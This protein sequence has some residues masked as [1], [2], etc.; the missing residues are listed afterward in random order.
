MLEKLR[1]AWFSFFCWLATFPLRGYAAKGWTVPNNDEL[2][3]VSHMFNFI[4]NQHFTKDQDEG[5]DYRREYMALLRS[6][7]FIPENMGMVAEMLKY[8]EQDEALT[9][10]LG[11][12]E[13]N[14]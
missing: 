1:L 7:G 4:V 5:L 3:R 12:K 9:D 6:V 11:E 10:A 14:A 2:C 13:E 8:Y